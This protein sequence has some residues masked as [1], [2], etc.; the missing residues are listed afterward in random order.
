MAAQLTLKDILGRAIHKEIESQH[1]YSSLSET[2]KD[3]S[4]KDV[5]R[6]LVR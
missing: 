3:N 2:V 5:F 1:I 4:A 6:D